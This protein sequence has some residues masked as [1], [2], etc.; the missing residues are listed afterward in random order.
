MEIH[1]K[2]GRETIKAKQNVNQCQVN[3]G[4]REGDLSYEVTKVQQAKGTTSH[5]IGLEIIKGK[6]NIKEKKSKTKTKEEHGKLFCL[7]NAII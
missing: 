4:Y 6:G 2:G 5:E 1:I 7:F 3:T